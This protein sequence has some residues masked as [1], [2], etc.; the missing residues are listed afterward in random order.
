MASAR[1]TIRPARPHEVGPLPR[2]E[3]AAAG[4]FPDEDLP[5][6]LRTEATPESAFA[7]AAEAG[8]LLIAVESRTRSPV[9]F[10]LA[11]VVDGSA[12]LLELDVH[13]DHG[14]QG[15]GARLIDAVAQWARD[16]GDTGLTLTTFVHLAWNAPY[17]RRLGFETIA[18]KETGPEL[19]GLLRQET[20]KGLDPA[21]RVAMRLALA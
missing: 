10:A 2:I 3:L 5:Q 16:R 7:E 18:R 9:G 4:L 20:A 11:G 1:Y 21:K 13:P 17:Y 12:H 14:R 8:R 15:L 19:E 6:E